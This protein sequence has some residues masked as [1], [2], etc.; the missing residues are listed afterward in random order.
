MADKI[1][2]GKSELSV[3]TQK[4]DSKLEKLLETEEAEYVRAL[5]KNDAD[6][7]EL[8]EKNKQ[9]WYESHK[10]EID[11]RILAKKSVVAAVKHKEIKEIIMLMNNSEV[12][13]N[14]GRVGKV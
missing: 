6:D 11:E 10:D 5:Y 3:L 8:F 4:F 9:A 1:V 13:K 2:Y 7:A 12:I 14:L